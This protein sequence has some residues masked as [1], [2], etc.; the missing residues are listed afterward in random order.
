M[1]LLAQRERFESLKEKERIKGAHAR[2]DVTQQLNAHFDN[3]RD[4]AQT[5]KIPE[6]LPKFQP[7]VTRVWL[8]KLGEFSIVPFELSRIDDDATNGSAMPA[9]ILGRRGHNDIRAVFN[10]SHHTG[11]DGVVHDE[12]QP[13]LARDF[14]ERVKVRHVQFGVAN[15]F[16]EQG[17]RF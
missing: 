16:G 11:A 8:S 14:G 2:A 12:R 9:Y 17:A 1:L 6:D 13:C 7:V 3:E 4:V 5:W 15:G 10:R